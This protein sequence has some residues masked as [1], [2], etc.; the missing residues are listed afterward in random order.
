MASFWSCAQIEPRRERLALH[1]L[2]LAGYEVYFPRIKAEHANRIVPLFLG[3]AFI[4]IHMQ[5]HQARWAPG[6][7]RLVLDGDRPARV[8]DAVVAD[9]PIA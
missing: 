3:Y 1:C 9:D 7:R 8:P 6:V 4:L 2:G 5:W